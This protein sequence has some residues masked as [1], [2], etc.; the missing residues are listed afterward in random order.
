MKLNIK[1]KKHQKPITSLGPLDKSISTHVDEILKEVKR[2][3]E[4]RKQANSLEYPAYF[5]I[6]DH[7]YKFEKMG[8]KIYTNDMNRENYTV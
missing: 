7:P 5:V 8:R 1:P 6:Y 4:L 3:K 2:H